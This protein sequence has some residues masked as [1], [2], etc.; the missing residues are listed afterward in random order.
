MVE[1]TGHRQSRSG[2][3][4]PL[5]LLIVGVK[6]VQVNLRQIA[7]KILANDFAAGVEAIAPLPLGAAFRL[8]RPLN[9]PLTGVKLLAHSGGAFL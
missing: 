1:Q 8:P 9:R 5:L 3:G 7:V 4:I 2:K 6:L